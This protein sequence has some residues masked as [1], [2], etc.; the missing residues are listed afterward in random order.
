MAEENV[1]GNEQTVTTT[2]AAPA[3][4]Q[5]QPPVQ[6]QQPPAKEEEGGPIE[7]EATGDP[8]LDIALKFFGQHGLGPE[9]PAIAAA[10]GGDFSLLKAELA[11]KGAQGWEQY[12]GLAQESYDNN[13]KD[14][15]AK[16]QAVSDAVSST[17]EKAGVDLDH[18]DKVIEWTRANADESE[19]A[20]IN[21][22]LSTPLGA[23]MVTSYLLNLHF[24]ASDT[25]RKPLSKALTGEGE[26]NLQS[27]PANTS[28]KLTPAQFA[29]ESEKL[30]RQ[31]GEGYMQSPQYRALRARRA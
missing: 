10:V 12:L 7:Y 28:Q 25:E 19:I 16:Q 21:Q 31:L 18:W 15:T 8:K 17:L 11:G 26:S 5:K 4:E 30:Y 6:E 3:V 9:H 27:T 2:I 24:E 1:Q 23:K 29:V 20:E 13:E 22:L 14:K